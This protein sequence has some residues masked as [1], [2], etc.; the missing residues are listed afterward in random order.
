MTLYTVK[1]NNNKTARATFVKFCVDNEVSTFLTWQE[2]DI[3][4]G[5]L[6]IEAGVPDNVDLKFRNTFAK[7]IVEGGIRI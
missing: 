6:F 2:E 5:I 4:D 3:F 1:I 7:N